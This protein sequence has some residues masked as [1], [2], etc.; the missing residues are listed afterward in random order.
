MPDLILP[1]ARV[2]HDLERASVK[3]PVSASVSTGLHGRR[4]GRRRRFIVRAA[5]R[6]D[7][8]RGAIGANGR[9]QPAR[10]AELSQRAEFDGERSGASGE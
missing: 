7:A 10:L 5:R 8:S 2:A 6:F 9:R 3:T 4:P 1:A